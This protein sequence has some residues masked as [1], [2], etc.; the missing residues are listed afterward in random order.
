MVFII[1]IEEFEHVMPFSEH[2]L[3]RNNI[4]THH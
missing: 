4:Y 2:V 3:S 1:Y